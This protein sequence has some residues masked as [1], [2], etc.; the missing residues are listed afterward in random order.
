MKK[1]KIYDPQVNGCDY[2]NLVEGGELELRDCIKSWE[3][4]GRPDNPDCDECVLRP[5]KNSD[6]TLSLTSYIYEI[7]NQDFDLLI[8]GMKQ[9]P[10]V[11]EVFIGDMMEEDDFLSGEFIIKTNIK[12]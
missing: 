11:E 2:D 10:E 6:G 9:V 12:Y 1:R 7:F 8:K 4:S 3:D 5:F